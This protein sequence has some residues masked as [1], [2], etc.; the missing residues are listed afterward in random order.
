MTEY[1]SDEESAKMDKL[2]AEL[3]N[4]GLS[5]GSESKPIIDK[6]VQKAKDENKAKYDIDAVN[7]D[8]QTEENTW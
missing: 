1:E 2:L 4:E 3:E 8:E 5:E 7:D 6:Q